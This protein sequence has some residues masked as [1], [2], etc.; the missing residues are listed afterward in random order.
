M[1]H[2]ELIMQSLA[3]LAEIKLDTE[4][5][6]DHIR[7]AM[8][9]IREYNE[10]FIDDLLRRINLYLHDPES[11]KH[12]D[13]RKLLLDVR[14]YFRDDKTYPILLDGLMFPVLG[15]RIKHNIG[16]RQVPLT[17]A[18]YERM[19]NELRAKRESK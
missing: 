3:E 1:E 18:E 7:N 11:M 8:K 9:I 19:I 15:E 16:Q 4:E 17:V 14:K 12:D 6:A 5:K 13:V 2:Y 10:E